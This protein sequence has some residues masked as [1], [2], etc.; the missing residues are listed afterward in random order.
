MNYK[1][2]NGDILIY[3]P[4]EFSINQ[5]FDCGQIFRYI[6]SNQISYVVSMDKFALILSYDDGV[7]IISSASEYFENYFDLKTDY[8]VIKAQLS[9]D[10]FLKPCCEYGYGIRILK[11]NLYEMIVSF[12]VSANNNIKRIKKSLNLLAK[13]FGKKIRVPKNCEKILL[14]YYSQ[15]NFDDGL[16]SFEN[17]AIYYYSFPTLEEL[18]KATVQDLVRIGLGYRA[19]Q[20]FKTIRMLKDEELDQFTLK[21]RDEKFKYLTSM[22]GVGS[23]VANCVLLFGDYDTSSFPVDTWINKVYNEIN[24]TDFTNRVQIEKELTDKYR[25][26]SGYAQ[27]YFFYYYRENYN[28]IHKN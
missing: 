21:T 26:M 5:I 8:K 11:Q 19:E 16:L 2:V 24:K 14:K 3:S 15:N 6:I 10:D 1:I 25:C 9:K 7:K 28:K 17:G 20:L 4:D 27:Q 22:S 18:K 13:N 12:I 23:K